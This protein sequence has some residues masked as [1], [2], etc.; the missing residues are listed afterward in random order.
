V[1][2]I[3]PASDPSIDAMMSRGVASDPS[4]REAARE[5]IDGVRARGDAAVRDYTAR[6]DKRSLTSLEVEPAAWEKEA[7]AIP[8]DVA[9]ALERAAA[10]ISAFHERQRQDGY[11]LEDAG[12]RLG[13]RVDPLARVGIYAPGGTARYPSSVLMTAVPARLA[14][15][16]EIILCT[17]GPSPETLAAARLA[18]VDRVF[19]IGG[20]QAVAA[21]AYGTESVPRVDKIVGPGNAWVAEAKRLVFGDVDIDAV[22]GPSEVMILA[23]E[24]AEPAL[25]AADLLAQAEHDVEAWPVLVTTS[26]ILASAVAR[27]LDA[28]VS[29]LPRRAIAEESLRRH[30]VAVIAPDLASAIRLCNRFA[31]EHLELHVRNARHVAGHIRSAGAI[32]IGP[33]APEAAGDY[34]A[35]PNHVLPTAGTARFASPLGVY[36]FVKRISVIEYDAEALRGQ[37][38]DISRLARVEGLQAH[39][40]SVAARLGR[41]GGGS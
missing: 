6:F 33:W 38:A 11:E 5:I 10:R 21:M 41:T 31:P 15:V 20:A 1:I 22:A 25:I 39:A 23:D 4:V 24:T 18:G 36:D 35:G 30:G 14:G 7:A 32:F 28:Q 3:V 37:A 27:E 16:G 8:P 9:K 2:K 34:L 26:E 40:R 13:L 19:A 17:P 29:T 12:V